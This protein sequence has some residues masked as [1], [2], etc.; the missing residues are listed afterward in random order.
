MNQP[1]Q[2]LK[3]YL[4]EFFGTFVLVFVGTGVIITQE[5]SGR[6][7]SDVVIAITFGLVVL[8]LIYS[9]G[10]TSGCHINPA[11]TIGLYA[12]QRFPLRS[13]FPYLLCQTTGAIAASGVLRLL[14]PDTATLGGTRPSGSEMQSFVLEC[15]LAMFLMFVIL[16]ITQP[17]LSSSNLAGIVIGSVITVEAFFAGS[18][19]GASMN[20][21]RSIAPAL[22]QFHF[23]SLWIYLTAPFLGVVSGV[24]LCRCL[25][26]SGCCD[27]QEIRGECA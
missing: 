2:S 26:P 11:V 20:P 14:F 8:S 15:F 10:A 18:I 19:S 6:T 7:P 9:L 22:M 13:V 5:V 4:A 17:N 12:A 21:A 24:V 23:E 16:S 1:Q 27:R 3:K 25:Q